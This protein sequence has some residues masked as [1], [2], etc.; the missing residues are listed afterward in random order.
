VGGDLKVAG[1]PSATHIDRATATGFN[2]PSCGRGAEVG[3]EQ[4]HTAD[5][6]ERYDHIN[7]GLSDAASGRPDWPDRRR[8]SQGGVENSARPGR[9]KSRIADP[10]G[11]AAATASRHDHA[12]RR[13][14]GVGAA[15]DVPTGRH[16]GTPSPAATMRPS[17]SSQASR[18]YPGAFRWPIM[19]LILGDP[20]PPRCGIA[21][22]MKDREQS[23]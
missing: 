11:R 16:S 17:T 7:D 3:D 6:M 20:P 2:G 12:R 22:E 21:G 5:V 15:K 1:R 10:V 23:G 8:L 4:P 18:V 14:P 19:R 13:D 9:L